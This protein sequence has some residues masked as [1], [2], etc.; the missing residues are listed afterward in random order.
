MGV[1]GDG[2]R[3]GMRWFQVPSLLSWL[4]LFSAAVCL[5]Q[6]Q[7]LSTS[8]NTHVHFTW[9][10]HAFVF[11]RNFYQMRSLGRQFS[12]TAR[13]SINE[14]AFQFSEMLFVSRNFDNRRRRMFCLSSQLCLNHRLWVVC[15]V[16]LM[17]CDQLEPLGSGTHTARRRTPMRCLKMRALVERRCEVQTTT[18]TNTVRR[19]GTRTVRL[20]VTNTA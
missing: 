3:V 8:F 6:F 16:L 18:G 13:F 11:T 12:K 7:L 9:Q 17:S 19:T 5:A 14:I 1:M 2:S 20:L 4:M 15:V 10:H